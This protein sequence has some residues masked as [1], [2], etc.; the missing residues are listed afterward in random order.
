[1][2]A[3]IHVPAVRSGCNKIG[4]SYSFI[5]FQFLSYSWEFL[6]AQVKFS[7]LY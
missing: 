1:M 4:F 3:K 6:Q 2:K 5:L 7:V